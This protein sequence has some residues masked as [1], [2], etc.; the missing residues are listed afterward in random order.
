[1]KSP[2]Q[3]FDVLHSPLL[4]VLTIAK[5]IRPDDEVFWIYCFHRL[6][7]LL[8]RTIRCLH[9]DDTNWKRCDYPFQSHNKGHSTLTFWTFYPVLGFN[10]VRVLGASF[11]L[12]V[13]YNSLEVWT[14]LY[15][16]DGFNTSGIVG[17]LMYVIWCD[18]QRCFV[19]Q[20]SQCNIKLSTLSLYKW[21]IRML[22]NWTFLYDL[23]IGSPFWFITR[24]EILAYAV[25]HYNDFLIFCE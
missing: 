7:R 12:K 24:Y 21:C 2:S 3:R 18:L 8:C 22:C 19:H 14:P 15:T 1:M 17:A 9:N 5:V 6:H 20:R 4:E 13:N 16:S 10:N 25:D 11:E 23:H